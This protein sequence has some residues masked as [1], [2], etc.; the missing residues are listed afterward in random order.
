MVD[1][2]NNL[3]RNALEEMLPKFIDSKPDYVL[4]T[5]FNFS[6]SFFES[7]VLPLLVGNSVDELKGGGIVRKELNASLTQVKTLVACDRSAHPEPKGDFRY[8]LLP[9]GLEKGRF[10]PKII[11]MSGKLLSGV[12]GLY[13]SVGSGNISLSGWAINREVVGVTPVAE[14]HRDELGYLLQWLKKKADESIQLVAN[15]TGNA[16]TSLNEEGET[17]KIIE[18]LIASLKENA[19]PSR[20]EDLPDLHLAL[21]A[22]LNPD[23]EKQKDSLISKLAGKSNWRHAT[24]VSPF[25]AEVPILVKMLPIRKCS[26]VP[27]LRHDG[28]YSFPLNTLTEG[29][30]SVI[31]YSFMR[32]ND[33]ADR[34]THAKAL[35]LENDEETALCIGSANFT[36]AA[37]LQE[38]GSLNNVEAMLRYHIFGNNA[39]VGLFQ[40]M[41]QEQIAQVE[42]NENEEGAPQLPPFDAEVACDWKKNKILCYLK[43]HKSDQIDS[44]AMEVAGKRVELTPDN[45]LGQS[46]EIPFQGQK[47]VRNFYVHYLPKHKDKIIRFDGLVTQYNAEDDD[48]GYNPRPRLNSILDFLLGLDPDLSEREVEQRAANRQ[49]GT[50]DGEDALE[51][52]YD[53]FIFFQAMYKLRRYY[54]GK[55]K[56]NM[57]GL[58]PFSPSAL[59]GIPM[60]YRA[61]T[62]QPVESGEARIGRYV[63]LTE[64]LETMEYLEKL[65]PQR[66]CDN[67]ILLKNN[68]TQEIKELRKDVECS[69]ENSATFSEFFGQKTLT[70]KTESFFKWFHD[71][72]KRGTYAY[73]QGHS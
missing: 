38:F 67:S 71:E 26:F 55:A 62:L 40:V 66:I 47:R 61:I 53:Y 51:P 33:G 70:E 49:G 15:A 10:H 7:N 45:T 42:D 60:L 29:D 12:H 65:I 52:I 58:D 4:F 3:M 34:Y 28:K 59:Q 41:N 48:L 27:S 16:S 64:L 43:I 36:S 9:V 8:G 19:I 31:E 25:W 22:E 23:T 35:I 69:L 72:L 5:T 30:K 1:P 18:A 17:R 21:P 37:M 20:T 14:K 63:Q 11:L 32:F 6:S 56:Q 46:V 73:H 57:D 44:I 39:W 13:L 2:P 50:G 54:T 68:L 24:V